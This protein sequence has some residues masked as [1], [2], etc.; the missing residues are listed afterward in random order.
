MKVWQWPQIACISLLNWCIWWGV[1]VKMLTCLSAQRCYIEA[2]H[3]LSPISPLSSVK[4]F[5]NLEKISTCY[6]LELKHPKY[7]TQFDILKHLKICSFP[8][9]YICWLCAGKAPRHIVLSIWEVLS[10]SKKIP[11]CI[12]F[13]TVMK[14]PSVLSEDQEHE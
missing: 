12:S 11:V 13:N 6:F 5:W 14:L 2:Q 1:N 4:P 3:L 9:C 7:N 8:L 10:T